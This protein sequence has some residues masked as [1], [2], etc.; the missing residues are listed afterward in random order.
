MENLIK[1]YAE[2]DFEIRF[3]RTDA[4]DKN[5]LDCPGGKNLLHIDA[6]GKVSLVLG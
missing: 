2:E 6:K 4:L 5:S 3:R 1:K